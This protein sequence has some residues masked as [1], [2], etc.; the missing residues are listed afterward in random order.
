MTRR[1][2]PPLLAVLLLSLGGTGCLRLEQP[3]P[4]RRFYLIEAVRPDSPART[5]PVGTL[6]VRRF[7]ISPAY[8]TPSFIYR[9]GQHAYEADFYNAFFV[10]PAAMFTDQFSRWMG[11]AG[12]FDRVASGSSQVRAR[13]LVEG[14]V[15]AVY[16]D[17]RNAARPE[18]AIELQVLLLKDRPGDPVIVHQGRYPVREPVLENTPEGLTAAWNRGLESIMMQVEREFTQALADP[19]I[20]GPAAGNGPR[21]ARD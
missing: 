10:P 15:T 16:G 13:Y 19:G 7:Q 14:L 20:E 2:C 5:E 11:E 9:T 3:R 18:A 21:S 8:E 12:L 1:S 17:Y 6:Q 4:E